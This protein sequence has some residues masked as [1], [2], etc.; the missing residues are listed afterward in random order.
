VGLAL[1]GSLLA[2]TGCTDPA[3]SEPERS[4][5]AGRTAASTVEPA[6][7]PKLE[8]PALSLRLP[9]GMTWR[10]TKAGGTLTASGST[11]GG[12]R[13][14]VQLSDLAASERDTR[15][16]GEAFLEAAATLKLDPIPQQPLTL[17]DVNGEEAWELHGE[18]DAYAMTWLGGIHDGR[19]WTLSVKMPKSVEGGDGLRDRIIASVEWGTTP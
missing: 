4:S 17:L 7:G 8:V 3:G 9:D 12:D 18:N 14:T 15:A 2:L 11:D 5:S 13:A 10:S 6:T 1:T 16:D 19:R